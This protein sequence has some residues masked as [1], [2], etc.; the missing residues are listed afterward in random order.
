ML[1]FETI[2]ML[3]GIL[4]EFVNLSSF[5]GKYFD[6]DQ[7]VYCNSCHKTFISWQAI[8]ARRIT[9]Q[10]K[11]FSHCL[12]DTREYLEVGLEV[13]L[14]YNLYSINAIHIKTAFSDN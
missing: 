9:Q 11:N 7:N 13:P 6:G 14:V 4:S 10:S 5:R 3:H 2:L 8:V 12:A 1:Y